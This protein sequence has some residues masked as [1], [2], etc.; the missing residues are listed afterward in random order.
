MANISAIP[1]GNRILSHWIAVVD[2]PVGRRTVQRFDYIVSKDDYR[3]FA[4]KERNFAGAAGMAFGTRTHLTEAQRKLLA[5]KYGEMVK[6]QIRDEFT[7]PGNYLV[8]AGGIAHLCPKSPVPRIRGNTVTPKAKSSSV[9]FKHTVKAGKPTD[10]AALRAEMQ[11]HVDAWNRII[12]TEG[13][14]GLKRR[15]RQW[16]LFGDEI[17]AVGRKYTRQ[18]GPAGAGKVWPHYP[19]MAT[20][21]EAKVRSRTPWRQ[22]TKCD[23]RWA[24]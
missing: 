19:D 22:E 1:G 5:R 7:N 15:L 11:R 12:E 13:M 3:T 10:I 20:G 23:N 6:A 24:G 8:A 21:G 16:E 4:K 2:V 9:T 17:E 18:L 14:V